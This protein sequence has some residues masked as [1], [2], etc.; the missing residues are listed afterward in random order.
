MFSFVVATVI[1]FDLI[2][3]SGSMIV[4]LS[5]TF[6][7]L[8]GFSYSLFILPPLGF[9]DLDCGVSCFLSHLVKSDLY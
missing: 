8:Y 6:C 7:Y 2:F 4:S 9:I 1:R 5:L 3:F